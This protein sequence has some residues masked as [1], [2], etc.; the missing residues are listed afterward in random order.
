MGQQQQKR[1]M[2]LRERFV[3]LHW[4]KLN[5]QFD[6]VTLV[7]GHMR[8]TKSSSS[9]FWRFAGWLSLLSKESMPVFSFEAW[10]DFSLLCLVAPSGAGE[11]SAATVKQ[12]WKWIFDIRCVECTSNGVGAWTVNAWGGVDAFK[13]VLLWGRAAGWSQLETTTSMQASFVDIMEHQALKHHGPS[14]CRVCSHTMNH[15]PRLPSLVPQVLH[16]LP[17]LAQLGTGAVPHCQVTDNWTLQRAQMQR[18]NQNPTPRHQAH[19][20][21]CNGSWRWYR[22]NAQCTSDQMATMKRRPKRTNPLI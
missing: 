2:I 16:C 10:L 13:R 21:Y 15:L 9:F 4:M 17:C 5:H 11:F 7:I 3:F 1:T 12:F 18:S 8:S 22:L 14:S 20:C 19:Q 6:I